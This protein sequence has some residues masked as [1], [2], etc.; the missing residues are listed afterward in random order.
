MV[1]VLFFDKKYF[2]FIKPLTTSINIH[3]PKSKIHAHTF[4]LS[5]EQK[6]ELETY[7]NIEAVEYNE[8]EFDPKK[9]DTYYKGLNRTDPLRFQLTCRRGEYVLKSMSTFPNDDLFVITDSD[10]LMVHPLSDLKNKMK[11]HDVGIVRVSKTKICSGFFAVRSVE[12]GR[13]YMEIFKETAMDGHLYLCKDQKSLAKVYEENKENINFL[14]LSRKYLDHACNE[15]SYMWS[16][17]KSA[18][19]SKEQKYK[20]YIK[21]LNRMVKEGNNG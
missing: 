1:I 5:D 15:D 3:E 21:A 17:H 12:A 19:G 8:M 6:K 4:N 16:G 10:T 14:F 2:H 9:S 7:P 20:R 13:R 11:S 18:F